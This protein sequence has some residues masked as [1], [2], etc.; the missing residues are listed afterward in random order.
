[1]MER[2]TI[3]GLEGRFEIN[4]NGD[5][6]SISRYVNAP[7]SGGRRLITGRLISLS[8]IK[9]YPGFCVSVDGVKRSFYIHRVL[10]DL[11]IEN[12]ECKPCINHI[13]GNKENFSLNN[14]E[15]C[16]HKEN[17]R[18]GFRTGLIPFPTT[19]KGEKSRSSK[20][21]DHQVIEIRK[22]CGDGES[23]TRIAK[24]FGVSPGTVGF[25]VRRQTWEHI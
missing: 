2:F 15:W 5:V 24:E 13:D 22:R 21:K 1:M 3:K 16:T 11:F 7:Q 19:G 14:L 12:P 17:I 9:G 18:Q 25:I 10:A 23:K 4:K 8:N 20:L 6:F